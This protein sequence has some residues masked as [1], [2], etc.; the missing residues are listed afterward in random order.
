MPKKLHFYIVRKFFISL[1]LTTIALA[2]LIGLINI[3]DVLNRVED[4][5]VSDWQII[6][7]SLLPIPSFLE[8]VSIF[9]VLLAS[10]ITLFSLSVKSEITV[11][12]A[13]GMSLWRVILPVMFSALFFG[14]FSVLALN[15]LTI[16]ADKRFVAQKAISKNDSQDLLAPENGIWLKQQNIAKDNEEIIIRSDKIYRQNLQFYNVNLWFFDK[17]KQFYQKIDAQKMF[18]QDGAWNLQN[19]TIN[20]AQKINHKAKSLTIATNLEKDFIARKILNNFE[21]IRLFSAYDLPSLITDLKDAGFSSRKFVVYF[22]SLMAKP[23]LFM[24]ASLIAAFFAINHIRNSNN[25][26]IFVQGVMAGLVLYIGMTIIGAFAS[27]GL[28]PAVLASWVLAILL[29]AIG[30]LLIFFKDSKF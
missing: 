21:N 19:V 30:F 27:S 4:K 5:D 15:P 24:A 13:A 20:D 23:F 29:L 10:M 7:L 14:Y 3:F 28:I 26:F 6:Q 17:N 9:L 18:L 22:H 2:L 25:I 12:R 1:F 8:D 16:I 11:M